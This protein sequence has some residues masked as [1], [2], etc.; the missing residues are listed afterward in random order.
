MTRP[1]AEIG[2]FGGS[3]FYAFLD[4][5]HEV[6]FHTPYGAPSAPVA[7]GT[8]E[9]RSVAF[10]PRHGKSHEHPPHKVNYR[11]N[12]W[13]MRELGVRRIVGPCAAG[14]LQPLIH[15]G[16]F[17]IL[18]QL[19]DRTWGRPDTYFDGGV[20]GHVSF[21]DPYCPELRSV[22][23]SAAGAMDVAAQTTGTVVVVQGPRFSTRAESNWYRSAGWDVIN[24]TQYPEAFLA[25]ELGI[26]YAGLALVTDYDTGLE[27]VEGIAPVSME[28]VFEVLDRNVER[29]RRLLFA[30]IP[31]ISAT[32]SCS[33]GQAL[34]SGPLGA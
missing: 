7:L 27:G 32:P 13:A 34:S 33:C 5:V 12:L 26:C 20:V 22:L 25:R 28:Q 1:S 16:D 19:V 24:M 21:A 4:D 6:H 2:V 15:P 30:A 3:G 11:A 18:D 14:S 31:K 8:V 17:V 9:G 29:S 23:A 10:L